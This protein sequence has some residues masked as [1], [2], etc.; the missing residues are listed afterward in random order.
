ME[1]HYH[2]IHVRLLELVI[3]HLV[4]FL[5]RKYINNNEKK[6]NGILSYWKSKQREYIKYI[7][8]GRTWEMYVHSVNDKI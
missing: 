5:Q 6:E 8:A 1:H 3:V 7:T 4:F 2:L